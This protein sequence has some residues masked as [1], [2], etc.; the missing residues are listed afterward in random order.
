M[1]AGKIARPGTDQKIPR[2]LWPAEIVKL[3][4][5]T[6][7]DYDRNMVIVMQK[8]ENEEKGYYVVDWSHIF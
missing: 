1:T 6:V 5:V 4:P 3:H 7:Y 8:D 2:A